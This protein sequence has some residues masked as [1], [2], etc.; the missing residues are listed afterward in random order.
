M[1]L[2]AH[3]LQNFVGAGGVSAFAFQGTN[4][5]AILSASGSGAA[6]A[7]VISS[8]ATLAH[9]QRF[10]V[11]PAPHPMLHRASEVQSSSICFSVDLASP[12]LAFL[13]DHRVAKR[14]VLPATGES[15]LPDSCLTS[16]NAI[17][18]QGVL[19]SLHYV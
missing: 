5:H 16:T 1:P 15:H 12:A 8:R 11:A 17:W 3:L 18:S 4:A 7:L 2:G 13:M 6:A 9:A 19:G 10:W 14:A